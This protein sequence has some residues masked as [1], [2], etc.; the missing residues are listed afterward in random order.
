M[1]RLATAAVLGML[2]LAAVPAP[3]ASAAPERWWIMAVTS[4]YP[5]FDGPGIMQ[6]VDCGVPRPGGV[7]IARCFFLS[8]FDGRV[9]IFP[10]SLVDPV[11]QVACARYQGSVIASH[12]W[13]GS[14]FVS[15]FENSGS[16]TVSET[17]TSASLSYSQVP[18][19][20]CSGCSVGRNVQ[21]TGTSVIRD[22]GP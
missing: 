22:P 20:L 19:F 8:S 5:V 17:T 4:N 21:V 14:G 16:C 2:C 11:W 7:V 15:Y 12:F 3:P 9:G 10:L 13:Y 1:R 6:V 18:S